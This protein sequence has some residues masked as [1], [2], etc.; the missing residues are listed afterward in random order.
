MAGGLQDHLFSAMA[1]KQ[2]AWNWL[3]PSAGLSSHPHIAPATSASGV[4]CVLSHGGK[5]LVLINVCSTP[6]N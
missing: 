1:V 2:L 5:G 6:E 3:T 4:S